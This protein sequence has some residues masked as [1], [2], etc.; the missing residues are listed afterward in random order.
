M[1]AFREAA[2][3]LALREDP[4]FAKLL[5]DSEIQVFSFAFHQ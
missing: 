2:K 4:S 5:T 3:D 1:W